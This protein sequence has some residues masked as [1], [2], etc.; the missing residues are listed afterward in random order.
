MNEPHDIAYD[1]IS[2]VLYISEYGNH[3]V[4]KY[5]SNATSGVVVA[6]GNGPGLTVTQLYH[7]VGLHLDVGS[8]SLFI[9]NFGA[10]TVV[11]WILGASSWILVAG[12]SGTSGSTSTLLYHP[13]DVA[14]DFMGNVY[15]ADTYNHRIQFFLAGDTNG[16]NIAGVTGVAGNVAHQLNLPF[17]VTVDVDLNVYVA[18]YNNHRVQQFLHN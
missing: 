16:T 13:G 18:D 11:R 12:V 9:A 14:L 17:G 8:N 7:P 10:H 5:T 1:W 3:R 2:N 15:V 6:G 4:M